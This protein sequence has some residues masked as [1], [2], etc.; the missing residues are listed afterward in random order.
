LKNA[1]LLPL[2]LDSKSKRLRTQVPC[3]MIGVYEENVKF[4][5]RPSARPNAIY[6]LSSRKI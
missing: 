5:T 2:C 4:P 6:V 1:F 3:P